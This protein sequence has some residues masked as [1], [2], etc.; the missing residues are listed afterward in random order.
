MI[1]VEHYPQSGVTREDDTNYSLISSCDM[2]LASVTTFSV[3]TTSP[4]NT[5]IRGPKTG[6]EHLKIGL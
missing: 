4:N 2:H 5:S 1:H 6:H 3:V